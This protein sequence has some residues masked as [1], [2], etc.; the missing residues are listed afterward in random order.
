MNRIGQVLQQSRKEE[1]IRL[2]VFQFY[3]N[4]DDYLTLNQ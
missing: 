1:D 2:T 4:V 3:R